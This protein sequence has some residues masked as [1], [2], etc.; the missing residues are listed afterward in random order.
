MW[1]VWALASLGYP[2]SRAKALSAQFPKAFPLHDGSGRKL[3]PDDQLLCF[4]LLYYTGVVIPF[5]ADDVS[6]MQ[7]LGRVI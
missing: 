6:S 3:E 2:K 1:S 7:G 5:A 4:D